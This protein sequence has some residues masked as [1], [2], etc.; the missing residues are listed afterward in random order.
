MNCIV[1][2]LAVKIWSCIQKRYKPHRWYSQCLI[3]KNKTIEDKTSSNLILRLTCLDIYK[4]C[5]C[6][7]MQNLCI[8][9]KLK[10]SLP[11]FCDDFVALFYAFLSNFRNKAYQSKAL[12][13]SVRLV[14]RSQKLR[15]IWAW[16]LSFICELSFDRLSIKNWKHQS[17]WRVYV[18]I[19]GL[20]CENC[21]YLPKIQTSFLSFLTVTRLYM[22]PQTLL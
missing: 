22:C 14:F 12:K 20:N 1:I 10:Y 16:M 6:V 13:M 7:L 5:M 9:S 15:E 4:H 2:F 8:S 19:K 21:L 11:Y 18:S 17:L 3:Y